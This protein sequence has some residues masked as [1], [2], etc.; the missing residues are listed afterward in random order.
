VYID[1][2]GINEYLFREKGWALRGG[3]IIGVVPGKKFARINMIAG[4][5]DKEIYAFDIYKHNTNTT[6]FNAWL[7]HKLLPAV[8]PDKLIVMD[9]ASFHKNIKTKEIIEKAKCTL[10]YLPPYSPDLNPIENFWGWLKGKVRSLNGLFTLLE[11]VLKSMI[12]EW[13]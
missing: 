12:A 11:H 9:N 1:E 8:G 5:C 7:E 13:N 6:S 4:R 3:Q 10:L 2:S